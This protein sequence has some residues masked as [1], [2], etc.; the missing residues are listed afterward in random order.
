MV[1]RS[2]AHEQKEVRE[3]SKKD[4]LS[5]L[6]NAINT[7]LAEE[8]DK[9]GIEDGDVCWD[10][11]LTL[12]EQTEQLAETLCKILEAQYKSKLEEEEAEE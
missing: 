1:L 2:S 12:D 9:L 11:A 10:I 5:K 7:I 4:M 3:M 6:E 8:Q